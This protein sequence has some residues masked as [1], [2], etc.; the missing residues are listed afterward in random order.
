MDEEAQ[1]EPSVPAYL[2]HRSPTFSREEVKALFNIVDKYKTII[3]NKSTTSAACRAREV[4]WMKIAKTFNRQGISHVRSADCLK[5][6]WDNMKKRARMAMSK[7]L[8]DLSHNEFD[9]TT[10]QMVAMMCEV[11]NNTGNVED[12][13]E[14]SEDLN[15]SENENHKESNDRPWNGNEDKDSNDSSTDGANE[16]FV[17][18][19]INFSPDE[20]NLLLQCVRQEKNIVFSKTNTASFNKMKN[21][22]WERIS[23]SY[24][25]L[26]PQKR[27][28]KVLRTKFSNMR[29]MVKSSNIK[30]Y[31]KEFAKKS[32]SLED[33]GSKIKSEPLFECRSSMDADNDSDLD[34]QMDADNKS[35]NSDVNTTLDPLS[36]LS[37][38]DMSAL[39]YGLL[40]KSTV[41]HLSFLY[42]TDSISDFE[43]KEIVRL[44]IELLNYKLETAKLKRKRI[45]DL[46]QADAAER[47]S[48]ARETALK[49]RAARLE[50]IAA[51]MK[52]PSAHPAL[53]YTAEETRAQHYL[54][55]YHTS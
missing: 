11:E 5:I 18:R 24:N 26:S 9:E 36:T 2:R 20:C 12:P 39:P 42:F 8:M 34:D 29:K 7:N 14:S 13:V 30:N 32:H 38:G 10:S 52:F 4:A 22:A 51:E 31:F 19:S 27:S 35:S 17:N 25:K 6:K 16:R 47:E 3:F 54:H 40:A 21:R 33:S 41:H 49:L 23:N 37:T 48:K 50:A 45:E 28:P 15:V 1:D 46:I 53:A 43:N 55:Q 44:K